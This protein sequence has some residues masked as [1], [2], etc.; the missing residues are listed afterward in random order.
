MVRFSK[1]RIDRVL[2]FLGWIGEL[3]DRRVLR[4]DIVAGVTVAMVLIPQ[5]MA[6][7]Q[8]ASLPP[9]YGLYAAFWPPI[10]AALFGSSRQLSTGS[11]ALVSLMTAAAL[12]PFTA[13]D[14]PE[15]I[16]YTIL[17]ALLVGLVQLGM[18]LLRLGALVNF[19][20]HPVVLGFTNAGALIIATSQI[21]EIFGVQIQAGGHHYE[22]VWQ[23][24]TVGYA[25]CHWPTLGMAM[26]GFAIMI[27]LRRVGP[28]VPG[29]LIAVVATSLIAWV[30]GFERSA[31]GR[32]VG[33]IPEGLP[34]F[35]IPMLEFGAISRLLSSAVTIAL[36]GFVGTISIAKAIATQTRQRIG[37]N[38][39]LIGQG[40]SNIAGSFF[41][42]HPV[43][44]SFARSAINLRAGAATG[45]SSVV[46]GAIV[47]V[48]LLWFTPLLYHLPLATLAAI[49]MVSVTG[50]I[51]VRPILRAWRVYRNDGI[52]AVVTF[53]MTLLF[54]PHLDKGILFGIGLSLVLYLYGTLKPRV[55]FLSRHPDGRLRDAAVHDLK[56]CDKI[57]VI[58]F[59]GSLY[60]GSA[61]YFEDSVLEKVS[62]SP[63][64]KYLIVD[65][66]GI[67]QIDITGEEMLLGV[68]RRLR[69]AGVEVLFAHTK[70]QIMDALERTRFREQLG[71]T[72]FFPSTDQALNYIWGKLLDGC[73]DTCSEDCPIDCPLNRPKLNR[74]V[75]NY[76]V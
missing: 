28:R 58:R 7:A 45:F 14:S 70:K 53:F 23:M 1:L 67:N 72:R 2:P 15:Y 34:A 54:A 31:G 62:A 40:L 29:V 33:A 52:V 68:V 21:D 75:T 9:V 60:F 37:A 74:P 48:V 65:A 64:L 6:N 73:S 32:V 50:L 61:G 11:V 22:R 51:Q 66:E 36:I 4:A 69:E 42:S 17:L 49:I 47:V 26:L 3:R 30:T 39:E 5:S 56:T 44:G 19:L 27:G 76:R 41:Q 8:L 18:G 12:Q 38:R 63:G 25:G 24:L 71:G 16:A 35:R 55:A 59:D 57:A 13:P 10:I 46:A 20:A 43:S